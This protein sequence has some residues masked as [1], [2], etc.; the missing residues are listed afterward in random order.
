MSTNISFLSKT[1]DAMTWPID[2]RT[3]YPSNPTL[4]AINMDI[5]KK[6]ELVNLMINGIET[7]LKLQDNPVANHELRAYK[8]IQKEASGI[9][10]Y[11]HPDGGHD[12]T[13]IARL[14]AHAAT[15]ELKA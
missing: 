11:K 14:L 3:K 6:G 8:S 15:Y 7:G 12:D 5:R 10:T 4:H 2:P 9:W 13:V 1:L